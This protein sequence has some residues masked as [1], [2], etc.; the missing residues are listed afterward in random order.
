MKEIHELIFP[1]DFLY[2]EEH[3]WVH[4]DGANV[5]IGISDYAQDRL[6]DI[7]FVELPEPSAI[8]DKGDVFGTVESVKSVSELYMPTAGSIVSVNE[9]LEDSPELVNQ[10][11]YSDG[12]MIV[13]KPVEDPVVGKNPDESDGLMDAAAY[14]D[15]LKGLS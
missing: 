6:G 10:S 8:F 5:K 3:T 4:G 2:F 7:V 15:M 13:L 11:P 14:V 9:A 1:E 12:W